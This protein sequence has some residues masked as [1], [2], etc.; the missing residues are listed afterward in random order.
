METAQGVVV[1][2]QD[3][4]N[5]AK[6]NAEL[7]SESMTITRLSINVKQV[8]IDEVREGNMERDYATAL[9]NTI[10]EKVG[11]PEWETVSSVGG[12]YTVE[13][14]YE[15][16]VIMTVNDIE[17]ND[18][19]EASEQ[20]ADSISVDDVMVTFTVSYDGN[21]ETVEA[22]YDRAYRIQEQLEFNA[23]EQD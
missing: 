12:I 9:Y 20:V 6:T 21:Y 13:V 18:E 1:Y 4:L 10:A 7:V 14:T 16:D 2:T 15:G 23:T 5:N 11:R 22:P 3:D 19:D 17:A 8:F